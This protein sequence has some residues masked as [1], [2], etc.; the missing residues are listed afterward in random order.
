VV[1]LDKIVIEALVKTSYSDLIL[2]KNNTSS[3]E[4]VKSIVSSSS[5]RLYFADILFK[6]FSIVPNET[7]KNVNHIID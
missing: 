1:L 7:I 5:T 4:K 2:L 6:P 3:I